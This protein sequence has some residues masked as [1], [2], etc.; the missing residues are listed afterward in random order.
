MDRYLS[1]EEIDPKVLIDDLETAVAR[2]TL[3]PVLAA[4]SPQ[5]IGLAELL[6]VMTQAFPAPAEHP[7][8]AVTTR[9]RQAGQRPVQR[10]RRAAAGR[11]REDHLR[12]VRGPDQPGPGVLRHAA[13]GRARC[14]CP[15]TAGPSAGTPTTTWTSASGPSP[16]RWARPSARVTQCGAGDICAV[17]K[18]STAETGDTLSDKDQP[19]LMEA[20]DMPRAAAADRDRGQVQG[21]RGQ[22]VAGAGPAGGRGPDAA[23]GEQRRDPPAGPVVHGRGARRPAAGPAEQPVRGGRGDHAAA[24]AAARDAGRQGPRPGPQRQA[25]RRPR[26]VRHLPRRGRAAGLGRRL[27]VRRQDRRRRGAAAV[28][29]VGGEGHPRPR[30]SRACWPATR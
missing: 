8:P 20:W 1:D 30:W 26:R 19:L 23:P 10:P 12:S 4:A 17:A 13:A 25:V 28:H 16:R 9:G 24:G 6:E 2:G 22:D 5:G 11:D 7:L 14:T 18:L 27:R 15:G 29:P 21:G 3:F